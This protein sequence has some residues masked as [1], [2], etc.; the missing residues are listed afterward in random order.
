MP[1]ANELLTAFWW[2]GL[3]PVC[4]SMHGHL[5]GLVRLQGG[6]GVG[7]QEDLPQAC[8]ESPPTAVSDLGVP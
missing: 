4:N 3:L 7:L 2:L 5:A 1:C 8:P 6:S